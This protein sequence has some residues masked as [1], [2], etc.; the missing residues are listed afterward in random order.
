MTRPINPTAP[1]RIL[2]LDGG[3]AK[4]FYTLGVLKEVEA[5]YGAPLSKAFDLIYGT[6]TGAIIAALLGLGHRVEEIHTLY[7]THIPAIMQP[8]QAAQRS[9]ALAALAD[10]VFGDRR[11]DAMHTCVGIV[12][13]RWRE[14][15]PMI[16]KTAADQAHGRTATFTPGFGCTIAEAVR[17]SCSA[18]PYFDRVSV[19]TAQGDHVELGDGGFSANNP[20]LY[21]I[22][23]A[24]LGLGLT[25]DQLR[26]LS[27]GV[28]DFPEPRPGHFMALASRFVV[29]VELVQK[30]LRINAGAMNQLRS[31]IFPDVQTV[32]VSDTFTRPD[33]AVNL[34]THELTVLNSLRTCGGESYARR[35]AEIVN[36]LSR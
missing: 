3:G 22:A 4:G 18:Y 17:A 25:A 30:V 20:T 35:E 34:L 8:S 9:A 27:I 1:F 33:L 24:R 16:F 5:Q 32:R 36:L 11:F 12:A 21:A 7:K 19:T 29:T 14:E 15:R 31:V 28:G 23:D 26:V 13:T 10:D 6:S 2:T